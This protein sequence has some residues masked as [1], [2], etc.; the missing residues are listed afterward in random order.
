[1]AESTKKAVPPYATYKSFFN[2]INGLRENG[3]PKHITK[4]MLPGS[5]SGKASMSA[6]LSVLGLV[7]DKDEPTPEMRQLADKSVDYS[8]KL[9]EILEKNHP[10]FVD[11]EVDLADTT[12]DKVTEKFKELGAGGSTVTKCVAFLLAAAKDASIAVSRYVKPPT[13]PSRSVKKK[14]VVNRVNEEDAD[15]DNDNDQPNDLEG[16]ERIVISV[17]GMDDW[18]IYVPEGLTTAQWKHGL[19]MA[20][21]ILDNYRPD[22][23]AGE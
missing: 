16:K 23:T 8:S 21:F 13:P 14:V 15:D 22:E 17:H 10:F 1:M 3:T 7:N 9:K 5:N 18:I 20:K 11:G 6:T 4:S 2:F 19:K 12:T